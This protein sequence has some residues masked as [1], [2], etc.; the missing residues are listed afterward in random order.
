MSDKGDPYLSSS[1]TPTRHHT[2]LET[3]LINFILH[4][5]EDINVTQRM[6]LPVRVAPKEDERGRS[7]RELLDKVATE[8]RDHFT[9][10]VDS[11]QNHVCG[12]RCSI[13]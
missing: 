1:S 5:R 9:L 2:L 11:R 12:R 8:L 7:L 13:E 6:L 3:L 4:E 10:G